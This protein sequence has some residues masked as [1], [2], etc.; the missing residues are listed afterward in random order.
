MTR[1]RHWIVL[2]LL[3][4]GLL[5]MLACV[6]PG[7][8]TPTPKIKYVTWT[9]QPSDTA[10]PTETPA[11]PATNTAAPPPTHTLQ[12]EAVQPAPST[13]APFEPPAAVATLSD[14]NA[15][16]VYYVNLEEKGAF[17]C[18]EALW[19]LKTKQAKTGNIPDDIRYALSLILSYHNEKIGVL[20]HPGWASSIGVNNVAMSSDG[21]V[22]VNLGGTWTPT[23]DRCDGKRFID[24]LRQTVRQFGVANI[25]IFLNGSPI[26]DVISRK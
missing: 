1:T 18:G 11:P 9:P 10:L 14:E 13:E 8:A 23:G 6:V 7:M 20:Y 16:K 12:P 25:Q 22:V 5:M 2:P 17:G 26:G 15:I 24:Q 21:A 19:Y 3:I 4:G